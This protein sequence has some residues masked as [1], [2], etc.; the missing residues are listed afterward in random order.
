M[1]VRFTLYFRLRFLN[2]LKPHGFPTW[3]MADFKIEKDTLRDILDFGQVGVGRAKSRLQKN[4][5]KY[6]FM[7]GLSMSTLQIFGC[8][9]MGL[10]EIELIG[11]IA[12]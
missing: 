5:I 8:S 4:F 7:Y 3:W 11:M 12:I 10:V 1:M 9:H 6:F 2:N